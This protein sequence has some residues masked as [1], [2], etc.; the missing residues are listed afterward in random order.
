M[1]S[2]KKL[3]EGGVGLFWV[4]LVLVQRLKANVVAYIE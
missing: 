2:L 3:V 4:V 1:V